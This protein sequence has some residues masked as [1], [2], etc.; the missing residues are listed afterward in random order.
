MLLDQPIRPVSFVSLLLLFFSL[1]SY[2]QPKNGRNWTIMYYAVGSN[3]S[4][5]DLMNDV[6][7]MMQGKRSDAYEIILLIDRTEG[8]SEDAETLGE[9]FY[10]TRLYRIQKDSYEELSGGDQMPMIRTNTSFDANMGD[11][12]TLKQFIRFCK[13]NYPAKHYMLIARSHGSGVGMCPDAESGVM[14]RL[15]P[16]EIRDQLTNDESV[17]I[18]GLDVCSMAGLENLYEWRPSP[19]KFS[20]D[21]IVSSAPLSAAWAYDHLFGRLGNENNGGPLDDNHFGGGREYYLDPNTMSPYQFSKLLI[22]EIYDSQRWSSWGLFDNTK[23]GKVKNAI[24]VLSRQ[25]VQENDEV[26]LR[27]I[28]QSIGYHHNTSEIDEL[29]LLRS[30][31]VD[32]YDFFKK[33]S[34]H[35]SMSATTRSL[36]G[37]VC[38]AIDELVIDSYYGRG[39]FPST[40]AFHEGEN[41]VYLVLPQGKKIYS[42]SGSSFWSHMDWLHPDDKKG[43]YA[44]GFYDWC[45]DGAVR[46]NRTVDN[47]YEYLDYLFENKGEDVNNYKW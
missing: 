31:Y 41:G 25:L 18:L 4:E 13:S 43:S 12:N 21:Y 40:T 8:Y 24:D 29:A 10:D 36:A 23:I 28:E 20:A 5:I 15:Y 27:L 9:N 35:S 38:Q 39:Y 37:K 22:E 14:D 2:A 45:S 19:D 3:S 11:A 32:A 44:Y 30:P 42:Q 46:G 26:V 1:V 7:E 33:I 6:S 47:F 34:E 17:D 16:G